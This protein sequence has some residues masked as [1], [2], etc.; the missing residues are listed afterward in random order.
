MEAL[1][2][3]LEANPGIETIYFNE[4]GGWLFFE[5]EAFPVK[6]TRDEVMQPKQKTST[7]KEKD[8]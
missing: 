7:N 8:K 4:Q 2:Q 3:H 6:K 1:I 5:H